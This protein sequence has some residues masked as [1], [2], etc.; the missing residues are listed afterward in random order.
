MAMTY[1]MSELISLLNGKGYR[2]AKRHRITYGIQN[3]YIPEPHRSANGYQFGPVDIENVQTYL[4]NVPRP[5]RR[6]EKQPE[7]A[8]A[9]ATISS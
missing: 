6:P 8:G 5:G 3:G 7:P 4:R 9:G 2:N 1:C